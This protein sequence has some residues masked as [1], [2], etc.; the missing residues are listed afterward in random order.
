V[1]GAVG[2]TIVELAG[3][4]TDTV[5]TTLLTYQLGANVEH[6]AGASGA[7]QTLTGNGLDNVLVGNTGDDVLSGLIGRDVLIGGGGS[8][9]LIGGDG[10]ANELHG[11]IGDDTYVVTV[12]GDT[13]V[14]LAGEGSDTVQTTLLTYV[15]GANLETL[16]FTGAGAFSGLGNAGNNTLTGGAGNDLLNGGLGADTLTGQGGADQYLFDSTLGGGNVDTVIGFASGA[17]RLLLD[18]GIFAGLST[19]LLAANAFV[20]GTAALDANDRILYD[21]ASGNLFYDA[22]GNGAGAAQLFATLQ[23]HPTFLASDIAVI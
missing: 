9:R 18:D 15:L 3:G 21:A 12:V 11:G 14:E 10:L 23:G 13:V 19:G 4:G 8:D 2:D 16:A 7:G 17:D 5:V 6:L 1:V 20:L 22:D